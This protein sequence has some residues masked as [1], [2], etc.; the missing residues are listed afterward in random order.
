[1]ITKLLDIVVV[2]DICLFICRAAVASGVEE[3]V[4]HMQMLCCCRE[5]LKASMRSW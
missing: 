5:G 1:M 4:H 3:L 2:I